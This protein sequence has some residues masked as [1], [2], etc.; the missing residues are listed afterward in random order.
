MSEPRKRD[1][2][3]GGGPKAQRIAQDNREPTPPRQGD[4]GRRFSVVVDKRPGCRIVFSTRLE[5]AAA[6]LIVVRL[7]AIGCRALAVPMMA[8][9]APG[10]QRRR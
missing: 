2:P 3:R 5:K 1:G 8:I 10:M 9:D 7:A 6:D 4:Q